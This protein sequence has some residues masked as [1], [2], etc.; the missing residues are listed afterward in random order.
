MSMLFM[1]NKCKAGI[2]QALD[3]VDHFIKVTMKNDSK[4]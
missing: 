1:E 3:K 4:V 2:Q